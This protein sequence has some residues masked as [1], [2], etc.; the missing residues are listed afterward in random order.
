MTFTLEFDIIDS[1]DSIPHVSPG[2]A[3][4]EMVI[5]SVSFWKLVISITLVVVYFTPLYNAPG[6]TQIWGPFEILKD[7]VNL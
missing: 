4:I 6:L 2:G 5:N 1:G 3:E 7:E